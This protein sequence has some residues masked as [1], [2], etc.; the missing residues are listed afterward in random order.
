MAAATLIT[1]VPE[2]IL[3]SSSCA[4]W[5]GALHLAR[6]ME[7]K[8]MLLHAHDLRFM[9]VNASREGPTLVS[10]SGAIPLHLCS[11]HS[12]GPTY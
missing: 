7:A 6:S 4:P 9:G 12:H 5:S 3:A 10:L 8:H 2:F 11:F 1:I